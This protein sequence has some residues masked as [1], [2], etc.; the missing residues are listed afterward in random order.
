MPRVSGSTTSPAETRIARDL[1]TVTSQAAAL[2]SPDFTDRVMLA[3]DLEPVPAPA[4]AAGVALRRGALGAF[5]ASFGDAWRVATRSGFPTAVRAQALALVLVVGALAAGSGV[6]AA[7]AVGLIRDDQA[8]PPPA[9]SLEAPTP[10]MPSPSPS[11]AAPSVEPPTTEPPSVAPTDEPPTVQ[12]AR[13]ARP[14]DS[15]D[16]H[17]GGSGGGSGSGGGGGGGTAGTA[18]TIT[19]AS[20]PQGRPATPVVAARTRATTT[21]AAAAA[22]AAG[23]VATTPPVPADRARTTAA[24]DV[25]RRPEARTG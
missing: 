22:A 15:G 14:T 4:H 18:P 1:E 3:I 24:S 25:P 6:A 2:P 7:G 13:T 20:G 10:V 19:V 8:A 21:V 23:A 11:M 9:P 17:G 5:L 16:N 12:P